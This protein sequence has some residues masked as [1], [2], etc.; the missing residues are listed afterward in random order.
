MYGTITFNSAEGVLAAAELQRALLDP[1][2]DG[3]SEARRVN[4]LLSAVLEARPQF[5]ERNLLDAFQTAFNTVR[6]NCGSRE[7][8]D[9]YREKLSGICGALFQGLDFMDFGFL[10]R[11]QE[12]FSLI[13][14]ED[15]EG[16][17]AEDRLVSAAE[18]CGGT[19]PILAYLVRRELL[20]AIMGKPGFTDRL[21]LADRL[22]GDLTAAPAGL[23]AAAEEAG[24]NLFFFGVSGRRV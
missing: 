23:V 6:A 12:D 9:Q 8:L 11:I 3:I 7:E 24:S 2:R 19:S 13:G 4:A 22:A 10:W 20:N 18:D 17:A 5:R 14:R 16:R 1:E 21:E 15:T